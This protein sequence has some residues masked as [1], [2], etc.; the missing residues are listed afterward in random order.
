MDISYGY[1][2]KFDSEMQEEGDY[3]EGTFISEDRFIWRHLNYF[4]PIIRDRSHLDLPANPRRSMD[5]SM[6]QDLPTNWHWDWEISH[7]DDPELGYGDLPYGYGYGYNLV[8]HWDWDP[9]IGAGAWYA[10]GG[11]TSSWT[12]SRQWGIWPWNPEEP[13]LT[14]AANGWRRDIPCAAS[15]RRGSNVT[16]MIHRVQ[17]RHRMA[18]RI[19]RFWRQRRDA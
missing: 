9:Q 17:L 5:P 12:Y 3:S 14:H 13:D 10:P 4:D 19:Q 2:Q 8:W 1:F 15:S 16:L 11:Y 7:T 6:T 18:E